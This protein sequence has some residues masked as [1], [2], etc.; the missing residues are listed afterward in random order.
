MSSKNNVNPD[1]SD[2]GVDP[3]NFVPGAHNSQTS[4]QAE[5]QD[6]DSERG[7]AGSGG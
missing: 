1:H 5:R 4:H 7:E 6:D 2:S 3:I